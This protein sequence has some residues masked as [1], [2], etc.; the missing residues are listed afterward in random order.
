M[1]DVRFSA[2]AVEAAVRAYYDAVDTGTVQDV[3]ACFAADAVYR[4]PGYEPLHGSTALTRFYSDERVIECG[5]HTLAT[6]VV[7]GNEAAVHGR[8]AGR[9]R[10][11]SEVEVG[12]ADF[13]VVD[14]DGRF[15]QRDT[16][17]SAPAV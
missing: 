3:V 9:L 2:A 15:A 7:A 10:D 5:R 13:F 16:F 1:D 14:P 12:F 6:V 17:F 11:A 4:R 8:F